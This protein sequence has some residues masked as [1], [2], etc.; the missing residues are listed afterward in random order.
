M[1]PKAT[2]Y[3]GILQ[4]LYTL[5]SACTQQWAILKKDVDIT[6]KMRTETRWESKVKSVE[7]LRYQAA[8]VREALIEVRVQWCGMT[9]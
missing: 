3:F 7:P 2:G 5:F 9:S 1:L 6:L 8:A 4:K